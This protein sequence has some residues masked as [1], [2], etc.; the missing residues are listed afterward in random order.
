MKKLLLL[1]LCVPLI[2]LGQCLPEGCQNGPNCGNC[3]YYLSGKLKRIG[4]DLGG[5]GA[6]PEEL[7]KS[8]Y[9]NGQLKSEQTFKNGKNEG[10]WLY[11]YEN[12][13]LKRQIN[14]KDGE[15]DGLHKGW[16]ENGQLKYEGNHKDGESDGLS[17]SYYK[18]GQLDWEADF[19]DGILISETCWDEQ[20]K[21]I[22][23][24]Y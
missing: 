13:N 1:L 4:P 11:F 16:Y 12:G 6:P 23:C 3:E 9:E 18:N 17:K 24:D 2:G 19:K 5:E 20:G 7:W 10:L 21:E 22:N 8:Y 14:Y 15:Y